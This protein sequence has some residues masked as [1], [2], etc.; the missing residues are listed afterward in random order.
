MQAADAMLSSTRKRLQQCRA[1]LKLRGGFPL[2]SSRLSQLCMCLQATPAA[3]M[4]AL[5]HSWYPAGT[6]VL[7]LL[8]VLLVIVGEAG[9]CNRHVLA[10]FVG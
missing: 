3:V 5:L 9:G 1:P 7:V 6:P 10:C 2:S 8:M 4:P